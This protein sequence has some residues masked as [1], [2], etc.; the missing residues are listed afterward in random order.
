M[1]YSQKTFS[2]VSDLAARI[3][4]SLTQVSDPL[5]KA[6]G[7]QLA[8]H[9]ARVREIRRLI[10]TTAS[11][12]DESRKEL[13]ALKSRVKSAIDG[14]IALGTAFKLDSVQAFVLERSSDDAVSVH[15]L[16]AVMRDHSEFGKHIAKKLAVLGQDYRKLIDDVRALEAEMERIDRE[17][18][19]ELFT[20]QGFI[21]TAKGVLQVHGQPIPTMKV[22]RGKK[23]AGRVVS[24]VP[25][26]AAV[27]EEP[28]GPVDIA[29]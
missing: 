2:L 18:S 14:S 15:D 28:V 3:E 23:K 20:L 29:A 10:E 13:S 19:A 12:H 4:A 25:E 6:T 21:S 5:A 16:E 22:G 27:V 7:K 26:A 11:R 9:H 1:A 8:D 24:L 17:Y